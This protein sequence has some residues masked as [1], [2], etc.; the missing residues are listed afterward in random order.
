MPDKSIIAYY[1]TKHFFVFEPGIRVKKEQAAE[2]VKGIREAGDDVLY[3]RLDADFGSVRQCSFGPN[4]WAGRTWED[5]YQEKAPNYEP[6]T[7]SR[8]TT[9]EMLSCEK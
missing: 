3:L 4:Y 9:P 2:Y 1:A 5:E 6:P 8:P 7:F